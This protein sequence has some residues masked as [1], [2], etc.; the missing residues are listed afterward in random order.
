MEWA[1]EVLETH[2]P[3]RYGSAPVLVCVFGAATPVLVLGY[4][5]VPQCARVQCC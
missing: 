4:V 3:K 1:S 2:C 5:L